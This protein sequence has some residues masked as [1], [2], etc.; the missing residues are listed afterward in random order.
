MANRASRR[1]RTRD[2]STGRAAGRAECR[3]HNAAFARRHRTMA[4]AIT[5]ITDPI[6]ALVGGPLG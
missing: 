4:G 5:A 6:A 3:P 2:I 1:R